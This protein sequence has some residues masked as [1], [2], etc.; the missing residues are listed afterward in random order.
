MVRRR[1]A[2]WDFFEKFIECYFVTDLFHKEI[3]LR[4]I[5]IPTLIK[6]RQKRCFVVEDLVR[7]HGESP[8]A[9]E[10]RGD[11]TC[12]CVPTPKSGGKQGEC[13]MHIKS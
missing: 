5:T 2:S 10:T 9:D 13:V 11:G 3:I 1:L 8:I 6:D 4:K 12:T 7:I